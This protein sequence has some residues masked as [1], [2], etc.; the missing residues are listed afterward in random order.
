MKKWM[1]LSIAILAILV[2]VVGIYSTISWQKHRVWTERMK[3]YENIVIGCDTLQVKH[4]IG[5]PDIIEN[6][7]WIY[8]EKSIFAI[9][10]MKVIS[11]INGKVIKLEEADF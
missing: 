4:F 11:I 6:N 3:N 10:E 2:T 8:T 7:K 9:K 1:I 5:N